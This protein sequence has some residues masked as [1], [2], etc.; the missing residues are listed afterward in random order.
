[1][2]YRISKFLVIIGTDLVAQDFGKITSC[3]FY[4]KIGINYSDIYSF[5]KL[6]GQNFQK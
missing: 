5:G 1:M 6:F 2:E 3:V 4:L